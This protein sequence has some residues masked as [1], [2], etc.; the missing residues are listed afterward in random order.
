MDREIFTFQKAL[1]EDKAVGLEKDRLSCL[2]YLSL[3]ARFVLQ[4]LFS[5]EGQ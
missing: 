4:G 2:L 5:E 1:S 3:H